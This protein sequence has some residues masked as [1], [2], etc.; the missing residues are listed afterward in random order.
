MTTKRKMAGTGRLVTGIMILAVVAA[1]AG[2]TR[3]RFPLTE[4]VN[5]KPVVERI[6]DVAPPNC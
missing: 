4:C 2:C 6:K 1:L 5:G 3:N